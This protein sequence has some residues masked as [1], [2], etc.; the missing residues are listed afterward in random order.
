MGKDTKLS[1]ENSV[2]IMG[3]INLN[4][5][6]YF[7]ASRV[8]DPAGAL[9]RIE[10]QLE[11]GADIIDLGACSTRP[12]SIP[13]DEKTEWQ[14]LKPLL[15]Q[16]RDRFPNTCFSIDTFRSG[17]VE[18]CFDTIGPFWI[19]DISAGEDDSKMLS[20]A[21]RL[22]LPFIAMHKRGNPSTMQGLCHYQDLLGE[23][24]HYF[25]EFD[26]KSQYTGI[27][28][29]VLDP[30][31]GF[32]KTTEQN[33]ELLHRLDELQV[34]QRE[35]LVGISRK[36]FIYKPLG[37]QPEDVL[38][39]TSAY[40]QIALQKGANILRVHDVAPAKA[41]LNKKNIDN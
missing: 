24:I 36:S 41:L 18:R 16:L 32:A 35:I 7:A 8:P 12:G 40:H 38:E 1:M 6:S 3:I 25:Q 37:L 28:H 33:L 27:A 34:L 14:R 11:D 20:L 15:I 19:N 9:A 22:E 31:F 21:G 39:Q 29:W 30:G 4:E 23:L 26:I 17:I 10:K 2:K 13:I 5:D